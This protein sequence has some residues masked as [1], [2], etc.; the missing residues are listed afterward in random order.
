ML[1]RLK[2]LV[3][4]QFKLS[5]NFYR[6]ICFCIKMDWSDIYIVRVVSFFLALIT[7]IILLIKI[8]DTFQNAKL[9]DLITWFNGLLILVALVSLVLGFFGKK[10]F[11]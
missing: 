9:M 6:G 4:K 10:I 2:V 3:L 8:Y 11:R 5:V 7:G 1:L